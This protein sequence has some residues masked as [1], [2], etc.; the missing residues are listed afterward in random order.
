MNKNV[1]GMRNSMA[2]NIIGTAV[3]LLII[4]SLIVSTI[5][6]ASFRSEYK[7]DHETTTYYIARTAA[8]MVNGDHLD[9]YLEGKEMEEYQETKEVLDNYC[10]TISITMIYIIRPDT[11]D[12]GSFVSVLN[13]VDNSVDDTDYTP[14]E[15]G[16]ERDTTNGDYRYLY[17][18]IYENG[19]DHETIFRVR[20]QD[21]QHKHTTTMVP[22][23][24]SEGTVQGILC[25]QRPISEL[26]AA[27]QPYF[28]KVA[29]STLVFA[30]L[31]ALIT[32]LYMRKNFVRPIGRISEEA[33]R[34]SKE[35]TVGA[36]LNDVSKMR[37]IAELAGSIDSM[38]KEM[39]NYMENL[40]AVTAERER[41]GAELDLA[42]AIQENSLPNTFPAFPNR[43]DFDIYA[44]MNTAK[45]VGGDF[46]NYFLI[47]DDHLLIVIGDVSGKG[48]PAALFMMVANIMIT[49]RG[50]IGG[51]PSRIMGHI[52]R[53]LCQ[54]N[55][56]DMFVTLW[57]GIL[58]ISTGKLT[59]VNAGHEDA[60]ICHK[61]GSFELFKTK[62]ELVAGAFPDVDYSDFEIQLN[63]G[64]KLFIYT[65]GV[66]EA[67]DKDNNMYGLD[68]MMEVLNETKDGSPFEILS[69]INES[70]NIFKGDA[71]QFD[72]ITML[73]VELKE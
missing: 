31:I 71:P 38:E 48:I 60:A 22:V 30:L 72:D 66:P 28:I 37:E 47:D 34:F 67:M 43:Q 73:C 26:D 42:S 44:S 15:L 8:S 5:G 65:D 39:V 16:Y 68:H 45:E 46:Y 59:A 49:D 33:V 13:V 29:I 52:N 50:H 6:V 4:L 63:K 61:G 23:K 62:H 64:D 2:F 3:A 18:N 17:R 54:Q 32:V 53:T 41:I 10:K 14:W 69:H 11:E 55:N 20:I 40:T 58:E 24:D 36:G 12:Y 1:S 27:V 25:V 21:G 56:E 7:K 70:V 51:K 35:N 57:L 9:D 19:S